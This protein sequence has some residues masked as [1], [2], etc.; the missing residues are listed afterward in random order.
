[1]AA[2]RVADQAARRSGQA[3]KAPPQVD[4]VRGDVNPNRGGQRQ[5]DAA[6]SRTAR[7]RARSAAAKPSGTRT[8]RPSRSKRP[9]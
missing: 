1:V 7:T 5:Y 8:R 9:V 2:H 6:P 3:V 4:G